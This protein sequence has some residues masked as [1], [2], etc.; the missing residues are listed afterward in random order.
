M[1][2]KAIVYIVKNKFID[3]GEKEGENKRA[4]PVATS[5]ENCRNGPDTSASLAV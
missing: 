5:I 3:F 2:A 1:L 4:G